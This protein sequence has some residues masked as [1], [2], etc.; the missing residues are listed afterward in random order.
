[1]RTLLLSLCLAAVASPSGA[2][3]ALAEQHACLNCHQVDKKLVGPAFKA[4]AAKYRGQPGAT[5]FLLNKVKQGGSGVWG[6]V[7]MPAMDQVPPDDARKIIDWL[8]KLP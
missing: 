1:M 5:E 8:L 2:S 4:V 7:P 3:E 6:A